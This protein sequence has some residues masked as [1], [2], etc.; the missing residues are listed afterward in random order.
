MDTISAKSAHGLSLGFLGGDV[1]ALFSTQWLQ[2]FQR[3]EEF[4]YLWYTDLR[5]FA[6]IQPNRWACS[7][8]F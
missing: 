3:C 5:R 7:I 4:F 8:I 6:T 2:L 1:I